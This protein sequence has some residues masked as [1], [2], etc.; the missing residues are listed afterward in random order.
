[1]FRW[2]ISFSL[3]NP[4]SILLTAGVLLALCGWLIPR[5]AVDVFPELN[6]P[7]VVIMTE[8]GGLAA[9]E[10]EQY[11]TIPLEAA[12]NGLPG[13]RKLRSS[14]ALGLS[15]LWL[16]FDWGAD[17]WKARQWVAE[18]LSAV[19]ESLPPEAHAEI[20]PVT[21]ITGEVMLVSLSS[22]DNSR[23]PLELRAFAEF[24]L[25]NHLLSVSGI[26]QVVAI[27]G[28][29]PEYQ[30][31]VRQE[32]LR[33]YGLSV[34]DVVKAAAQ[35]H[36]TRS[37]GF[38]GNV[39]GKE[40]P[41]RQTAQVQR[42]EDIAASVLTWHDGMPVTIG[43]VAEVRLAPAVARGAASEKGIDA[44]I[45]SVQ[46]APGVNTLALTNAL[47]TRLAELALPDGMK[48]NNHV[49]R[50]ADFIQI[51][52]NNLRKVLLEAVVIVA[53]ILILFLLNVRTTIITLTAL[54]LSLA[55]AFV[56]MHLTG[57]SINV[58]TLGGLAVALGGLVD[59]A[60]IDVENV[61]RR[62]GG[63]PPASTRAE[64]I[65]M[66]QTASNE[67][68][69][70]MVFATVIIVLV[71]VPLL[72]LGGMEGRFFTPLGVTYIVS[73]LASLLVAVTVT[74]ALCRLLLTAIPIKDGEHDGWLVRQI[75]RAYRPTLDWCLRW[76]RSV[77][78][79]SATLA[80]LSLVVAGTFGSSFLPDFKE[81]SFY[82]MLNAPPGT[83]LE[84]SDRLVRG[85]ESR[86]AAIPGVETVGRRTGRAERDAHAEP[87]SASEIAVIVSPGSQDA[88][89]REI[90][91][92]LAQMPGIVASVGQ[93]IEHRLSHIL[94]GTPAAIA[95]TV[96]GQDLDQLRAAAKRIESVL[97][98]LPGV[99]DLVANREIMV[100]T[101]P[102]RF[103]HA[104]LARAGLSP[105]EAAEQ[106]EQALAGEHVAA[107]NDGIRRYDMMVRLHPDERQTP[108]HVGN[109]L[110]RSPYGPQV[111]LRE[112]ADIGVEMASN[113]IAREGASR[114][115][116]V[117]L[118][119]AEGSNL[120]DLV[121]SVQKVVDPII[122][123]SGLRV[124]YGG[125]FEAQQEAS[126]TIGLMGIVVVL[127]VFLL[128]AASLGS[129]KAA[130][131]VLLNLPLSLIGGIAAVF[132]AE[133]THLWSNLWGLL[134]FGV[135]TPPVLSIA[136]L[137]GFITLFGIAV[138]NGILLVNQYRSHAEDGRI[139]SDAIKHG[140]EE[141]L[142]AILMTALCA[143]IGLMPLAA[144]AGQPGAEILAPLSIVVLGGLISSTI[145]NLLVVPAAYSWFFRDPP[146][147][148]SEPILD[149]SQ[150]APASVSEP[151]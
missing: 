34:A 21:S 84:E 18:R 114:K 104:D 44:V 150:D 65:T 130:G 38:L 107:V 102:I 71:F 83:S 128:L 48:L 78:V 47:D 17:I 138:R 55:V 133:S 26:S 124:H 22:P 14:S 135:Y 118:N 103:R 108:E 126:R 27:G 12:V 125:Q 20:A 45:L 99:R 7:T 41:M 97:T 59:D 51:S 53:V 145:L 134:G 111:L 24:E 148:T 68:R 141:R 2:L 129:A 92:I 6:A 116:V 30:V 106:V 88:V 143:A 42:P 86:L 109:L 52:V 110:L 117:S 74:P 16:E 87:P 8:A 98:P 144:M 39:E 10:V 101:L 5:M 131:L 115:A 32:R 43:D 85:V 13:M 121:A 15:I 9:D 90:D 75:K 23:T 146:L 81:G 94:S 11:V 40:L 82:V 132:I 35:A 62:L 3:R 50:Q 28:E 76:K 137:V 1:M 61:F 105:G 149:E 33:L 58:M 93:P 46:K 77:V 91:R 127:A 95:I 151:L 69:S 100:E 37:A 80:V 19:T 29:L 136:S 31:L 49:F 113:L 64:R 70:P 147:V 123:E 120:G 72:F 112:V 96:F 66:V 57:L 140:S 119:V 63:M 122:A 25:R 67:I 142:V 4:K 73:T 56:V 79:G 54:P 36:S 139:I 89:K 60:I